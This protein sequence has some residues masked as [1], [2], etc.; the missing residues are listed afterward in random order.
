VARVLKPEGRLLLVDMV[1]HDRAEF[2]QQMGH[3]WF[4]FSES[5]LRRPLENAGF[6]NP[7]YRPLPLNRQAKGPALFAATCWKS[8][9]SHP[10]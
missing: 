2:E 5:D 6:V 1:P 8:R 9:C 10:G 4:G 7:A 3:V